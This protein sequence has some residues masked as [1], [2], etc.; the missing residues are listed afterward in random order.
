MKTFQIVIII[1][2]SISTVCFMTFW[3]DRR[4]NYLKFCAQAGTYCADRV[5]Q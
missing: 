1:E 5:A 2:K 4:L 3:K